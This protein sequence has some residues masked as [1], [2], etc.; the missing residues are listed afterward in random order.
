MPSQ[1]EADEEFDVVAQQVAEDRRTWGTQ[2][3]AW[4]DQRIEE[5]DEE[6]RRRHRDDRHRRDAEHQAVVAA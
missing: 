4:I 5:I 6:D 3:H 2:L 1:E